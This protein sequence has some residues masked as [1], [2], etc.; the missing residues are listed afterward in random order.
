MIGAVSDL[1][2]GGE[3]R[4]RSGR[5][6]RRLTVEDGLVKS[7]RRNAKSGRTEGRR[8]SQDG[9]GERPQGSSRCGHCEEGLSRMTGAAWIGN[10]QAQQFKL[11]LR[12]SYTRVAANSKIQSAR[13]ICNERELGG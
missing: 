4:A 13:A 6:G 9:P 10:L 3:R 7:A 2:V 1:G 11:K 12:E 8:C 5:K